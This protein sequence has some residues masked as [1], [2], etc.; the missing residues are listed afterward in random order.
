[1]ASAS[2][3]PALASDGMLPWDPLPGERRRQYGILVVLLLLLL[4]LVYIIETTDVPKRDTSADEIPERLARLVMEQK[5]EP[6]PP[7]PPEPEPEQET[8]EEAPK[9]EP[10][11]P[12]PERTPERVEQAR[13]RARQEVQVFEDSLA[14]LRDL[15]PP[16]SSARELRRGGDQSTEVQR[17]LLTSR[18]GRSSGGISTGSVSSGGGGGGTLEGGQVAQ[19]ES[20]IAASAQAAATV[21]QRP[22]GTGRR[23][24]EQL[25]RTFDRY[26]GRINS[27]YQRALRGNPT[28]E[29]TVVLTLEIAPDGSVTNASIRSSELNDDDLERRILMVVRSMDFGALPVS[30]WKG[31]YPINFFP[32]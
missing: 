18:A 23:T 15:A 5:Q 24:T 27:V 1:M 12:P 28:L 21:E 32:G 31:D 29:G 7:R 14:G 4:P 17:D 2:H 8:P 10:E 13:E 22:D 3:K 26:G 20:E 9:P 16:V 25:R 30:I 6:E 19:V 11:A